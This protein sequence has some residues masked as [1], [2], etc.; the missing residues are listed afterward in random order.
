[1]EIIGT[2]CIASVEVMFKIFIR[3]QPGG[4]AEKALCWKQLTEVRSPANVGEAVEALRGWRRGLQRA[5]ELGVSTPD[6]TLLMNA[7][8]RLGASI[9]KSST[10][11]AFRMS[12]TRAAL[13]VD[14]CPTHQNAIN[15]ADTLVAEAEGAFHSGLAQGTVK[16]KAATAPEPAKEAREGK[17]GKGAE[18]PADD[19][20]GKGKRGPPACNFF[21]TEDGCKK[22]A[23][24]TYKHDW[25]TLEKRGR[26]WTCSS[27]KHTQRECT[28][29]AMTSNGKD[30]ADGG[31]KAKGKSKPAETS[32]STNPMIKKS[33]K[34]SDASDRHEKK[35]DPMVNLLRRHPSRCS[36][37]WLRQLRFSSLSKDQQFARCELAA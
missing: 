1:M 14:I 32:S 4:L 24:C 10:Q 23:N 17:G 35:E 21:G 27:T 9:S 6:P 36:R 13:Q 25:S 26:C 16:V 19:G 7:L 29:K 30:G 34:E 8:D 20:G 15:Y 33:E 2:R 3:Y 5:L 11:A 22:G 28:V 18:K 31:G 12:S 37:F